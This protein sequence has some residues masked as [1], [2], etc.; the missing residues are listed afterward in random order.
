MRLKRAVHAF[1]SL[2]PRMATDGGMSRVNGALAAEGSTQGWLRMRA[3]LSSPCDSPELPAQPA[4]PPSPAADFSLSPAIK[5]ELP[6]DSEP[7]REP[8]R[9]SGRLSHATI[10]RTDTLP[11]QQAISAINVKATFTGEMMR[12]AKKQLAKAVPAGVSISLMAYGT[13]L[14]AKQEKA[15]ARTMHVAKIRSVALVVFVIAYILGGGVAFAG[16]EGW[17]YADGVYFATVTLTTVGYGDINPDTG[18][19]Q[20][21]AVVYCLVGFTLVLTALLLVTEQLK[22][23]ATTRAQLL[24]G[25]LSAAAGNDRAAMASLRALLGSHKTGWHAR[26]R[27]WQFK[28]AV[29]F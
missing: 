27:T 7:S 25:K 6:P 11:P 9:R 29:W 26:V 23:I 20:F 28:S 22:D 18:F 14:M 3:I 4:T 24:A 15:L 10:S 5:V 21:L 13:A 2:G 8:S 16:I 19:G 12:N 1:K 17:R